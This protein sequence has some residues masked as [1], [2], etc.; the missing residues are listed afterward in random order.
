MDFDTD[1]LEA[2]LQDVKAQVLDAWDDA[3]DYFSQLSNLELTAWA[4]IATGSLLFL[5]GAL[6]LAF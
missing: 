1:D 3:V 6:L 4:C 5:S 2:Q